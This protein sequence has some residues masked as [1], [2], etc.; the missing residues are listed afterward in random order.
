MS[1]LGVEIRQ[2]VCT[3]RAIGGHQRVAYKVRMRA[4]VFDVCGSTSTMQE[5]VL[6]GA[7]CKNTAGNSNYDLSGAGECCLV[8]TITK[9]ER[10]QL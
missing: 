3:S 1:V 8:P 7:W 10:T 6:F 4:R 2:R 5:D 9:I